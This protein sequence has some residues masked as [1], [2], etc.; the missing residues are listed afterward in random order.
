MFALQANLEKPVSVYRLFF[1]RIM[2]VERMVMIK[3]M[4]MIATIMLRCDA[5]NCI[6]PD[7]DNDCDDDFDEND[8]NDCD[9]DNDDDDYA[10]V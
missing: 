9:D 5:V 3:S 1:N 6:T 2:V 10:Q 7:N 4:M 8:G